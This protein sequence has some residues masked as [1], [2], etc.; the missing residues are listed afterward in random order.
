[1]ACPD[2]NLYISN[3]LLAV[4]D[5]SAVIYPSGQVNQWIFKAIPTINGLMGTCFSGDAVGGC[6]MPNISGTVYQSI[7]ELYVAKGLT[8]K[9]LMSASRTFN[10][11]SFKEGDSTVTVSD[12]SKA[13]LELYKLLNS[14]FFRILNLTQYTLSSL[15]VNSVQGGDAGIQEILPYQGYNYIPYPNN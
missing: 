12:P 8:N 15:S 2:T 3:I 11:T 5:E 10:L 1:M 7:L 14:E 4:G 6:I 13:L 9:S